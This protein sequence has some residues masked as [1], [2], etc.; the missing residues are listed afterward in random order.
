MVF[1]KREDDFRNLL[2]DKDGI[3]SKKES[4]DQEIEDLILE[5]ENLTRGI[6]DNQSNI[7]LHRSHWEE[8]RT[9]IVEL[10]KKLLESNSRLENQQKE[11]AV[12]DERIGEIQKRILGAKEQESVIREKKM[13]WKRK[14]KF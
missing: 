3:L 4:I 7:I 5:N 6:R 12:L 1:L 10:E 14:S 9:H 2:F 8:T 13:D 11:I